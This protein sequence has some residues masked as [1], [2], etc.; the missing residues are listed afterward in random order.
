MRALLLLIPAALICGTATAQK[1]PYPH[2]PGYP[3]PYWDEPRPYDPCVYNPEGCRGGHN[4]PP[5]YIPPQE[6]RPGGSATDR[7]P[8]ANHCY[9]VPGGYACR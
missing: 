8:Y 1:Y 4:P 9:R 7:S 2:D 5:E 6:R 3:P